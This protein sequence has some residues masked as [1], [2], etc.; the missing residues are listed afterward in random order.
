MNAISGQLVRSFP[1]VSLLRVLYTVIAIGVLTLIAVWANASLEHSY[2]SDECLWEVIDRD[3][4]SILIVKSIVEGG[5]ADQAGI[6]EGD[7]VLAINGTQIVASG[8]QKSFQAQ[9]LLNMSPVE[10]SIPYVVERNGRILE[11]SIKLISLSRTPVIEIVYCL[12]AAIWLLIGL[13]V[14]LTRPLGYIQNL[15]FLTGVTVFFSFSGPAGSLVT[16]E[17][18]LVWTI[19]SSIYFLAWLHFCSSFPVRQQFMTGRRRVILYL[20]L[21]LPLIGSIVSISLAD[22]LSVAFGPLLGGLKLISSIYFGVGIWLLFR[23]YNQMPEQS[24]RRPMRVILIGTLITAG[25]LLYFSLFSFFPFLQGQVGGLL[26]QLLLL[27]GIFFVA[28][29]LSFGYAIFR[30]QLMDMRAVVK[31]A[32]VYTITTGAILGLY[33]TLALRLGQVLGSLLGDQMDAVVEITILGLFLLL[34]EPIRRTIQRLV[35]RR[36]F[37]QYRDYS[38]HLTEYGNYITEAIGVPQVAGLIASTL[39][40]HLALERVCVSTM[41]EAGNLEIVAEICGKETHFDSVGT[42]RLQE[43]LQ[44]SHELTRLNSVQEPALASIVEQGFAYATG[45]YAGGRLI[46]A[47][48]LSRRSDEKPVSGSQISFIHGIVSQGAS[49]I[50]AARLYQGELERQRYEEELATARRIQQSL[51]PTTMPTIPGV[52]ISAVSEPAMAVGGDYYEVIPLPGNRFLTMIA[53][54][55]GKGLPASLYMAELHG[56]VRIVASIPQT[57]SDMLRLLNQQLCTVL[58]N[59]TFITATIGIFD[60]NNGTLTMARAGHMRLIRQR[61]REIETFEPKGLPLGVRSIDFFNASLEEITLEYQPGDRYILYSDGLSEAMNK[62]REEFSEERLFNTITDLA[63]T[64]PEELN[65]KLLNEIAVF[66]GEA[67][68]NDDVT[69]VVVEMAQK[70][71]KRVGTMTEVRVED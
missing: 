5:R 56:M 22:H 48:L 11:L 43:M 4:E 52:E 8:E 68:Q 23:G 18:G 67:E 57:P 62:E 50:E 46:G 29:P 13:I 42:T 66:R 54:V 31:T 45:L 70:Q 39:S 6:Q 47:V 32:L 41:N 36:F 30:Y 58:E 21:L 49:G 44:D 16:K 33:I 10:R 40:E 14:A 35:D 60:L 17:W 38:E 34:F 12:F 53:D 27:P 65:Q 69:V 26:G 28:L 64:T 9:L 24:D 20:L 7:Q 63:E 51:L 3:G 71:E 1:V 61:E 59:G 55:S 19:C 37:P 2:H 15:F 25:V